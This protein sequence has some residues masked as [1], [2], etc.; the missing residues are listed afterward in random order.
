[1]SCLQRTGSSFDSLA[2]HPP[3]SPY[4][5]TLPLPVMAALS[6]N[7]KSYR[8]R[9]AS[10]VRSLGDQELPLVEVE[11]DIFEG[12][13]NPR[14]LLGRALAEKL[15][16]LLPRTPVQGSAVPLGYRGFIVRIQQG[17]ERRV[18][19]VHHDVVL[20][21]WLLDSGRFCLPPPV[22]ALVERQLG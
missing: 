9:T 12:R 10:G 2:P 18:V 1:M 7:K 16:A 11:L 13:P 19:L 20:E 4:W 8:P 6:A 3:I 17:H 22:V 14:W 15:M 5:F 21:R